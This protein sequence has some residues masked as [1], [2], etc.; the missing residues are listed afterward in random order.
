M[1]IPSPSTVAVQ[2]QT[3]SVQNRSFLP[4]YIKPDAPPFMRQHKRYDYLDEYVGFMKD[5]YK[6]TIKGIFYFGLGL[7]TLPVVPAGGLL[8]I[9][10][11]A[12]YQ[13][14]AWLDNFI[15]KTFGK[16]RSVVLVD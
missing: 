11:A 12:R 14:M 9:A 5:G 6:Y 16:Q 8:M 13:D 10:M 3:T 15:I 1:E 4:I 7:I 2:T